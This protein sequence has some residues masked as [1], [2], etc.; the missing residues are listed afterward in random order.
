MNKDLDERLVPNGEYRNAENIEISTS[1]GSD[2]GAVQNVLGNT[3]LV[4]K[5]YDANTKILSA[6][7]WDDVSN[8]IDDLTNPTCIGSIIDYQN[9]KIYWF[10]AATG[11]SCIAEYTESTGV[12]APILVDK[13]SILNFSS[14]YPITG[15][16]IIDGLLLWTDNQSE[17]KKIKISSFKSGSADFDFHTTFNGNAFTENDITVAK[18]GPINAP[19]LTMA[20]SKRTGNG[21]GTTKVYSRFKF[22][23]G[24]GDPLAAQTSVTL[25]LTPSA[26]FKKDDIITL[27]HTDEENEEYTIKVLITKLNNF[28]TALTNN[29]TGKIQTIPSDTPNETIQWSVLLDEEEPMFEKKFVRF[30]LRWK[31]KDG[32]YSTFSPFSVPAFLPTNFEYKSADGHNI[33]MLNTLR[34][35]TVNLQDTQPADVDEVDILYKESSNNLVYVV[36]TLKNN[37]TSY[38]IQSEIIGSVVDSKQ[39]LRPWDNVPKKALAQEITANRLIYANYYQQYDILKQNIPNVETAI[40]SNDITT[41]K[42]PQKSLKSQRTYQVGAVYKD[43]YGRETPVFS[44]KK[45]AKQIDKSF[46]DKVNSLQCKLVNDAPDFATHYKFFVKETSNEYYNIALDRFYLA[47]DGN[48]WL[49]FP[50]SERNKIQDDSYLILKKQH[51]KDIAISVDARYKVLDIQNEAPRNIKMVSQSVANS[52]LEILDSAIN[53]PQV[54]AVAFQLKGP[55]YSENNKFAD[56]LNGDGVITFTTSG[57]TTGQYKISN[58][59]LNG[60]VDASGGDNKHIYDFVLKDPIKDIDSTIL[61]SSYVEDNDAITIKLFEER[62]VEKAEFYGRFFVKINRNSVFDTNIIQSFPALDT[63]Y[64][65]LYSRDVDQDVT[66][67]FSRTISDDG[68]TKKKARSDLAWTDTKAKDDFTQVANIHPVLGKNTFTVYWAGVNY[69]EDWQDNVTS[70]KGKKH[71]ELDTVNQFLENLSNSGTYIQFAN[72]NG[73]TGAIYEITD[74]TIDY[75]FRRKSGRNRKFIAGKRRAY[76]LT[77]KNT[78]TG[79]GYDD[80]FTYSGSGSTGRITKINIMQKDLPL[81]N[82]MI[83]SSNPA[84]FE[85][86]PKESIDLDLY[87]EI[88][89]AYPIIKP[90]MTVEHF[91]NEDGETPG[92]PRIPANTTIDSITDVNN[93]TLSANTTGIIASGSTLKITDSKGIYSFN[94]ITNGSIASS[95]AAVVIADGDFHGH[96]QSLNWF[97]CYSFGNGVES[98]RLRDDFNAVKIDKGVKVSAPL[99]EQYKEEHKQNGLIFSG[100]FNSTSGINRLNQF[101]QAEPITKDINPYYGSI[102]KLHARFGDLITLCEDKIL[103]MYANKD[104]LYNAD[105]S[106]NLTATNRVL[107]SVKPFPG[108]YGISKDPT[109]FVSHVNNAYF[110]DKARGAVLALSGTQLIN[111]SD[112]GMRDWFKDNLPASTSLIGTYNQNKGLYNLTVKGTTDY[113]LS[114]D[115]KVKGWPS[116]KS[117]IPESGCSLNNKYYTFYNGEIWVHTNTTRNNFYGTQYDS[118]VK[119]LINDVSD[120]IKGFKTISYEGT[121]A[122]EYTYQGVITIDG[123]GND[124]TDQGLTDI[125]IPGYTMGELIEGGYSEAQIAQLSETI[126]RG[127]HVDSI[128]TNE[129]TGSIREFKRK[130]GKYF[131]YIKGDTTVLSNVDSE[132][133]S[134]QGIGQ[135]ASISGNTSI[136]GYA[137][138]ITVAAETGLTIASVTDSAASSHWV[139]D[140]NVIRRYNNASGF[141]VDDFNDLKITFTADNGY[142][143][144]SSQS[145]SSQSP[146]AFI[147]I[148]SGTSTWNSSTGVLRLQF[149]SLAAS[150][151]T[152]LAISLDLANGGTLNTYSIAGTYDVVTENASFLKN[153][154]ATTSSVDNAYSKSAT[155]LTNSQIDFGTPNDIAFTA[156]SGYYFPTTPTCEVITQD[157]DTESAYTIS[158]ANTITDADNN[159]TKVTFTINYKHG[160]ANVT[161]DK[162]LFTAKAEKIFVAP[163]VEI[164]GLDVNT[165]SISRRGE[166]RTLTV[167]G[168]DTATFKISRIVSDGTKHYWDGDSW[169]LIPTQLTIPST[170]QYAIA[171]VYASSSASKTFKYEIEDAT[172]AT[173]FTGSNPVT[174]NQYAD[175]TLTFN[176]VTSNAKIHPGTGSSATADTVASS[177]YSLGEP[178]AEESSG[179]IELEFYIYRA[180]AGDDVDDHIIPTSAGV[181][182]DDF[183]N[184]ATELTTASAVGNSTNVT[185]SSGSNSLVAGMVVTS[186]SISPVGTETEV[187]IASISNTALVLSSA[188]TIPSGETLTFSPPNSYEFSIAN[189]T[190]AAAADTTATGSGSAGT[191]MTISAVNSNIKVGMHISGT[192][193]H[194]NASVTAIS[195]DGLTITMSDAASGTMSGTYSFLGQNADSEIYVYKITADIEIEKYGS[196]DLTSQLLLDKFLT[197][198]DDSSSGTGGSTATAMTISAGTDGSVLANL[199]THTPTINRHM[200]F[201]NTAD[202]TTKTGTIS[203]TG[204]F[205]GNSLSQIEIVAP[206]ATNTQLSAVTFTNKRFASGYTGSTTTGTASGSSTKILVDYSVNLDNDSG[207]AATAANITTGYNVAVHVG[208]SNFN[209]P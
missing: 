173:N 46:A 188:Q 4:G 140:G 86:E 114:Y 159:V 133:F 27:S 82:D 10:I 72:A 112:Q 155:Y 41:I 178:S 34:S 62:E 165:K 190:G 153:S 130:E 39:I 103:T 25:A 208:G 43:A 111:I 96:T 89:D 124:L 169:E 61:G 118:S 160:A 47:D 117:F 200:I 121:D 94:V 157:S 45:A 52:K 175:V 144:P 145:I 107:G 110:T 53:A 128:T 59:G 74:A 172:I 79:E 64:N 7:G 209:T 80:A 31:Y 97:N 189:I 154:V 55:K 151:D 108:E 206:A 17:P 109:S 3:K 202:G 137:A 9:N 102:Q 129:D 44:N 84:I 197:H 134:V 22:T 115:S 119:V 13:N 29:I 156:S 204:N 101:I 106:A 132:E 150:A 181:T 113:T 16:N 14:S 35:L 193:A 76:N 93:F 63:E 180:A 58:G 166:N 1:E 69:G 42:T 174:L 38:E 183:T 68:V 198:T 138:A 23:D 24:S 85:T 87:Y 141:N 33:G 67:D 26:N 142:A 30:A 148:G 91:K 73:D 170:G 143:L 136:S 95:T 186:T 98:D 48:V 179:A 127:W 163:T 120:T 60:E 152:N 37:E 77:I 83:S 66:N 50:S 182:E 5:T 162:L 196:A 20:N 164:T 158:T 176:A 146:T 70:D 116:F 177:Y 100:I 90:S 32:E 191:A 57:G 126:S 18:L 6:T 125:K 15:V 135:L 78:D 205:D 11:V 49:S 123:S 105:G 149:A 12:I 192:N 195:A 2:V 92:T 171:E 51:D 71:N 201:Q 28:T 147:A 81:G 56:G 99:A 21:T 8:A 207:G 167:V 199:T 19:T 75:Q 187:T 168:V 203:V 184:N 185:L 161:G 65:I 139:L 194:A 88:S 131:N 122:K 40:T 104:A 36:D 54:G